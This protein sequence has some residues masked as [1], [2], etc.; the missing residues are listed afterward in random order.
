[1]GRAR[2]RPT[3]P[4]V[5]SRTVWFESG[6]HYRG[7][8]GPLSPPSPDDAGIRGEPVELDIAPDGHE[9][10]LCVHLPPQ[11][12]HEEPAGGVSEI[13]ADLPVDPARVVDLPPVGV[14]DIE[15]E[16]GAGEG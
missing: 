5:R 16:P 2:G 14:Q 13:Q 8:G 3:G 9:G 12:L 10:D 11:R 6:K 7:S 15:T 4:T 1:M